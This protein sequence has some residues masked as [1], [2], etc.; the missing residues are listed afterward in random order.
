M[1]HTVAVLYHPDYAAAQDWAVSGRPLEMFVDAS[2]Y[3][4]CGCLCQRPAPNWGHEAHP[5]ARANA[6]VA[7]APAPKRNSGVHR[8]FSLC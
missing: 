6:K 4:W 5:A 3:G 2:D 7:G 8:I 1:L